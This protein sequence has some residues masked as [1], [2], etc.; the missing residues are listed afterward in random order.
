MRP[1][2]PVF[3]ALALF[4]ATQSGMAQ[5]SVPAASAP[6]TS[7][8]A[9]PPPTGQTRMQ[10]RFDAANTTHDGHLTLAQAKAAKMTNVVKHFDAIDQGHKGYVTI[11]DMKTAVA[12]ARAA[13][14]QQKN[15]TTKG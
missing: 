3:A 4:A 8:V 11:D 10:K 9:T 1:M 6:S 14:V 5:T 15:P 2:I 13:K 12:S 7:T